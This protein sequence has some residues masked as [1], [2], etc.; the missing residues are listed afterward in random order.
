MNLLAID[1][2]M[3]SLHQLSLNRL[4]PGYDQR[5]ESEGVAACDALWRKLTEQEQ[6]EARRRGD[7]LYRYTDSGRE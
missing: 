1:E 5:V 2:Y 7:L 6:R 3:L 4:K